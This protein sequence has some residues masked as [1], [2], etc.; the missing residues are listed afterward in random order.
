MFGTNDVFYGFAIAFSTF[1]N[2]EVRSL[3]PFFY[4]SFH[5]IIVILLFTWA[6]VKKELSSKIKNILV[7]SLVI[8]SMRSVRTSL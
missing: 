5:V 7:V 8:V 4:S 2:T 3:H 6:M 1:K